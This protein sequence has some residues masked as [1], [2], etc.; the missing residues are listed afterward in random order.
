MGEGGNEAT[1]YDLRNYE[2]TNRIRVWDR[3]INENLISR[4]TNW[5]IVSGI[6]Y[7][8]YNCYISIFGCFYRSWSKIKS[9]FIF[10]PLLLFLIPYK[11]FYCLFTFIFWLVQAILGLVFRGTQSFYFLYPSRL[12]FK[13]YCHDSA[14][15]YIQGGYTSAHQSSQSKTTER[16]KRIFPLR[17]RGAP[18]LCSTVTYIEKKAV[19]KCECEVRRNTVLEHLKNN[20]SA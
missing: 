17:S 14:I 5:I 6:S 3:L 20:L 19:C 15:T 2:C 13:W 8:L 1:K 9:H 16:S 10:L 18:S 11:L 4:S 12:L 7:F